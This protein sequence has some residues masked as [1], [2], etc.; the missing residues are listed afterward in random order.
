M[1]A[2]DLRDVRKEISEIRIQYGI[3]EADGWRAFYDSI[4]ELF[5]TEDVEFVGGGVL[6]D[7]RYKNLTR[8]E[9]ERLVGIYSLHLMRTYRKS[10]KEYILTTLRLNNNILFC[11]LKRETASRIY[12]QPFLSKESP[13]KVFEVF[14]SKKSP[15]K[16][17]KGLNLIPIEIEA[18]RVVEHKTNLFAARG[19][20]M[21]KAT[22]KRHLATLRK[23]IRKKMG[24][25]LDLSLDVLTLNRKTG[26]ILLKVCV[27]K[28]VSKSLLKYIQF[29][30]A[31]FGVGVH[32]I[33]KEKE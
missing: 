5:G 21:S 25:D 31:S 6:V 3:S 33:H 8:S 9:T 23:R 15:V 22:V 17:P 32:V 14:I 10:I 28:K 30:F 11:S 2:L 29:Y 12:L 18:H 13:M 24:M 4:E 27:D 20:I 16:F 7:G 26:A 19:Y 1:G